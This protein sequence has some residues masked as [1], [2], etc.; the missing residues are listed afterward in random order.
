MKRSK[1]WNS[2]LKITQKLQKAGFKALFAGGCVRDGL[3]GKVPGDFDIAT[4]AR[5][6]QVEGLFEKTLAV[7]KSFGVIVV[8]EQGVQF[9]VATFR[10]EGSY[11]DGRRPSEV[12]YTDAKQDA[13]RRDFTVNGMFFD[14]IGERLIDYVGGEADLKARVIRTIGNASARFSEDYLRM[15]RAVRFSAQLGFSIDVLTASAIKAGAKN[16][17]ALSAER[18]T[19]ELGKL[20]SAT[21][22]ATGLQLLQTLGLAEVLF[23]DWYDSASFAKSMRLVRSASARLTDLNLLWACLFWGVVST[24][25]KGSGEVP[26]WLKK[27]K[28]SNASLE[29]IKLALL[30]SEQ[31]SL[32][33]K[34]RLPYFWIWLDALESDQT[35]QF[36]DVVRTDEGVP[37]PEFESLM[38]EF[39]ARVDKATG[40][41]QKPILKGSDLISEGVPAGPKLGELLD[42]AYHYQL[43]HLETKKAA[44]LRVLL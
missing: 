35:V 21:W 18:K 9:E 16:I 43:M 28:F 24:S 4:S 26:G 23:E 31:V 44:L 39:I 42:Q 14:P 33:E 32:S 34:L 25:T 37:E 5:P 38:S 15:L 40:R 10:G 27:S 7:G 36:L 19:S 22:S 11:S 30:L 12:H 6:E 1:H 8:L 3:L 2:A 29:A 41:L 20:L 17:D 13:S